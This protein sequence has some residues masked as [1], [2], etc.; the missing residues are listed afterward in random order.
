M[1]LSDIRSLESSPKVV[2]LLVNPEAKAPADRAG[3]DGFIGEN[4]PPDELLEV[5]RSLKRTV[6]SAGEAR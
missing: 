6:N 4:A 5:I 1:L 3:A 2:V